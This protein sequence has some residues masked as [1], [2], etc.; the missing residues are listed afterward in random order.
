M[1]SQI[2]KSMHLTLVRNVIQV[3]V[4]LFLLFAGW[5]F[6]QF[7]QHFD[8]AGVTPLIERPASV[9]AFLPMSALVALRVWVQTGVF[10]P[11]HPAALVILVSV[12]VTSW[13]FPKA[14]C[15]WLC[16]IGTLSEALWRLGQRVFG[17]N[18]N[19]PRVLDIPL[20]SL[21]YLLLL[22][23]LSSVFWAMSLQ[24]ALFF[25]KSDYNK[26]ADVKM[27]Q[28]YLTIGSGTIIVLLILGVASIFIRNFWCR[29]LC[30]Y[31]ALLGLI[32]M[33]SP[34]AITRQPDKCT[35]CLRCTRACPN[36]ID[37]AHQV[38]VISPEC[39]SCLAC[40]ASCPRSD[41][42]SIRAM[43]GQ[44]RVSPRAFV[45]SLLVVFFGILLAAQLAGFWQSA[46]SYNDYL[47]LIPQARF[48]S[49]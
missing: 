23:A 47:S 46:L 20:R 24:D 26:I 37:V 21:K 19:A 30:P 14:I 40:I 13:L 1:V 12:L 44:R 42:L 38:N 7:V 25:Q 17:R 35:Q 27:L 18:F 15:A 2:K 28:F 36:R 31:G 5:R 41:A 16:P 9:E 29:Y 39:S 10:D 49:H 8:S 45:V 6:S 11:I 43:V 4:A 34:L 32:G 48:L 22:F 3:A 33:A